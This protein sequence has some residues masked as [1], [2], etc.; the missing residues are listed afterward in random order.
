MNSQELIGLI[1]RWAHIIPA[2]ILVG[3]TLG[4]K[5]VAAG[6]RSGRVYWARGFDSTVYA[7]PAG[8]RNGIAVVTSE[9]SLNVL[10]PESGASKVTSSVEGK[11]FAGVAA[12][13][14][15]LWVATESGKLY[16]YVG[17]GEVQ[18]RRE[19]SVYFPDA[20]GTPLSGAARP[21]GRRTNWYSSTRSHHSL[22]R[23][24]LGS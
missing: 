23:S 11:V 4:G 22:F 7:K 5:V 18:L 21:S 10:D 14:G 15:E 24:W 3:G 20:N 16:R 9:G 8:V 12:R 2:I 13:S 17:F 1:S 6:A 19:S